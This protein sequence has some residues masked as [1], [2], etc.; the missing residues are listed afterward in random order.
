MWE[1]ASSCWSC[2]KRK[3]FELLGR[4]IKANPELGQEELAKRAAK[5][6]LGRDEAKELLK[7]GIGK[8]WQVEKAA[9]GKHTFKL[10]AD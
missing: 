6:G 8:H 1:H 9:H 7:A 3:K 4:L 2:I 10:V 5:K